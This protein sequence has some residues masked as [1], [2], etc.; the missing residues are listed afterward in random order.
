MHY[1]QIATKAIFPFVARQKIGTSINF[2]K[3][4]YEA[5]SNTLENQDAINWFIK[6]LQTCSKI[7]ISNY[8]I[9]VIS[10]Y[11]SPA[12]IYLV[13]GSADTIMPIFLPGTSPNT[14]WGC[15]LSTIY[16][17][18]AI[19][20]AGGVYIFFDVLFAVQVLHIILLSKILRNKIRAIDAMVDVEH[21]SHY[22]IMVNFRN[23]LVLHN[24]LLS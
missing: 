15:T 9:C 10:F 5:N 24:E 3:Q 7:I 14:V 2:L 17:I 11:A 12:I 6:I 21:P 1:L 20:C 16:H 18:Y 22:E 19:F 4:I 8:S 23:V 13:T